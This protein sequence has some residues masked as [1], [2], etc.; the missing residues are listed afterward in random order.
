[1]QSDFDEK[2][3]YAALEKWFG[4]SVF[5]PMQLDIIKAVL[6]GKDVLAML[7]T[8]GGKSLCFQLPALMSDGICIVVSPLIALI[9]DQV[10]NLRDRGIPALAVHSGMTVREISA[11]LD[12][13][14]YGNYKFLYVSPERLKTELFKARA[15]RMK[16]SL[17][18]VD[19]AHC[20]SQWGY[21]F[22]PEYLTIRD[23]EDVLGRFAPGAAKADATRC[24]VP[25]LALTATATENVAYDIMEK[26]H[27]RNGIVIRS[28]FERNNLS[29][30]VRDVEDKLGQL[31]RICKAVPGTGIVYVRERRKTEDVA[32]F[33]RSE[34]MNAEPYHAGMSKEIRDSKQNGWKNSLISIIVATN[35][36][37]MGIDKSDVR[38]VVH[39][40]PPESIES[41]FQEAGRAGRD[42]KRAY[43]VLL[44]N[45]SD[46]RKL[47]KLVCLNYP[48]IPYI[49]NIYQK[50]FK[51]LGFAYETGEGQSVRFDLDAFSKEEKVRASNAFY[52]IKYIQTIGYWTLTDDMVVSPSLTFNVTSSELGSLH[53]E[54]L[55]SELLKVIM[56]NYEGIFSNVVR[57]DE[58]FIAKEGRFT[59]EQVKGMLIELSRKHIIRYMP[60]FKSPILKLNNE[61]FTENN[62]Y[63][64]ENDYKARRERFAQRIESVIAYCTEKDECRS[65]FLVSYFGQEK[66]SECG[67]CDICLARKKRNK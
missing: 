32:A 4:Y 50:V 43:A 8:G 2:E 1:M 64:S 41:Y 40:D 55:V 5:R 17:L 33:L 27:F 49:K 6:S 60:G 62:L 25:V 29:Y 11:T 16:V 63:I 24:R 42:G 3:I 56:R 15:E 7:P 39:Y 20:V 30:I 22:R 48:S 51:Y 59:M 38:F 18:V 31:S 66:T 61:R 9:K 34:G 45:Q 37:G 14:V 58:E 35:A 26:L 47:R 53:F 36:F 19:E 67:I 57:I 13:A 28:G 21:D 44:Y 10:Q 12:N 46:I 54:P 65:R 23:I 52:A